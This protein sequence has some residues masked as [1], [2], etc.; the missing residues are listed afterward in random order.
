MSSSVLRLSPGEGL[1][2]HALLEEASRKLKFLHV[3]IPK[4]PNPSAASGKELTDFMGAEVGRI[5]KDQQNLQIRYSELQDLKKQLEGPENKK[6]RHAVIQEISDTTSKLRASNEKLYR[7]LKEAPNID[8]NLAKLVVERSQLLD[9]LELS[10]KE[11]DLEISFQKLTDFVTFA[12]TEIE[13]VGEFRKRE[14]LI[15]KEISDLQSDIAWENSQSDMEISKAN[16]SLQA[17]RDELFTLRSLGGTDL[18]FES[19]RLSSDEGVA[20]QEADQIKAKLQNDVELIHKDIDQEKLVYSMTVD[21]LRQKVEELSKQR[22]D[23]TD[24]AQKDI[25]DLEISRLPELAEKR[26]L[27]NEELELLRERLNK[28]KENFEAA[29]ISASLR[30]NA[31]N[32]RAGRDLEISLALKELRSVGRRMLG[33][34]AEE[35]QGKKK[36]KKGKK[37]DK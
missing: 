17:I 27:A 1:I 37:N 34:Q 22:S 11:M 19:G 28:E 15:L 8:D 16:L 21:F 36:S 20:K 2:A 10:S 32:S 31:V 3:A 5:L 9:V 7:S 4:V 18:K 23:W 12:N 25:S 24:K 26:R 33:V 35:N 6:Q 29:E 14:K 13:A 30:K